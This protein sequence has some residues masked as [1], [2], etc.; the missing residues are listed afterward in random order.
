MKYALTNYRQFAVLGAALLLAVGCGPTPEEERMKNDIA[1]RLHWSSLVDREDVQIEV[2]DGY[3]TL[4]GEVGSYLELN[5]AADEAWLAPGVY[6]VENDLR[7]EYPVAG[8]PTDAELEERITALFA[9][10]PGIEAADI[11]VEVNAG[12]VDLRGST[13]TLW[14]KT[15][16]EELAADIYGVVLVE[17]HLT[18]V[19]TEAVAD[20]TLADNV[21]SAL[22][23]RKLVDADEVTVRVSNSKITLT[24]DVDSVRKRNAVFDAAMGVI[25]VDG[26]VVDDLDVVPDQPEVSAAL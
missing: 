24:G 26:L 12:V 14:S 15:L 9:W 3:V 6:G 19:P 18:V 2:D 11:Q 1:A 20:E 10:D 23:S 22:R 8:L 21:M 7:V 16:A 4:S 5:A 25:G 17:D 13:D